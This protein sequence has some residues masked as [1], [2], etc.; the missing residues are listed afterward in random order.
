M[1]DRMKALIREI[2]LI[3]EN[4]GEYPAEDNIEAIKTAIEWHKNN[5]RGGK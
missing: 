4:A 3:I 1:R 2:E 5:E